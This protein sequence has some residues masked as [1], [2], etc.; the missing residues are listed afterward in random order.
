MDN[1]TFSFII[2]PF[3]YSRLSFVVQYTVDTLK[4]L[5]QSCNYLLYTR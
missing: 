2:Y 5:L 4:D 3:S 1:F